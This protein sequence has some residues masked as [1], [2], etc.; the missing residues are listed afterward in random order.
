MNPTNPSVQS[1][2][3]K[4]NALLRKEAKSQGAQVNDLRKQYIF[5]L[6][7]R[8]IFKVPDNQW[9]LLGG[10]ALIL[11]TGGGRY[12]QDIDLARAEPFYNAETVQQ[13]LQLLVNHEASEGLFRFDIHQIEMRTNNV[14]DYGYGTPAARASVIAYLGVQE[15]DRFSLDIVQQRHLQA[16]IEWIALRQVIQ[17]ETLE[18]PPTVPVAP[19]ESHLADKICAMYEQHKG[20]PS[21]RMRD[22]A[23]IVRI[24]KQLSFDA[25]TLQ[26]KLSHERQR[27][28]ITLPA[29][30][31]SPGP[32]WQTDFPKAAK[33]FNGYPP[34]LHTLEASL[35]YAGACLTPVLAGNRT[36]GIWDPESQQWSSPT[37]THSD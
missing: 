6:F 31:E 33:T 35:K 2:R 21:T 27:R 11:R 7:L 15:F 34:E 13:E 25:R 16:P 36:N 19:L 29:S 14:D 28:K 30:L 18:D 8:R 23:D 32:N 1:Q 3:A 4:I 10:N 22:L 17:H 12:T 37:S 5:S 24:V 26:D 20:G 9:L